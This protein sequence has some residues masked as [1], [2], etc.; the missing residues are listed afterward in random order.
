[1][2]QQ[3]KIQANTVLEQQQKTQTGT[4]EQPMYNVYMD[5]HHEIL[6]GRIKEI[7][8]RYIELKGNFMKL[9][10]TIM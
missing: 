3:K 4:D 10:S 9:L 6:K 2:M 7:E 8:K 5:G 1:M